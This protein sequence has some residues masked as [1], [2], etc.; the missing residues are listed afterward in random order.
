MPLFEAATKQSPSERALFIA[1]A[2]RKYPDLGKDL[3]EMV[4]AHECPTAESGPAA[5]KRDGPAIGLHAGEVL[6]E[7]FQLLERIGS[8]GMGEVFEALDLELNQKV[9]LKTIR[10]DALQSASSIS[11][12]KQE[13]QLARR[14]TGPNVC[15]IY[16]FFL[17]PRS[18]GQGRSAFL[19]MELLEGTTLFQR[20]RE[21]GSLPAS[22]VRQI[23]LDLCE[24]LRTIHQVGIVH[25]DIKPRNVMLVERDGRE[26]AVLMDFGVARDRLHGDGGESALQIAGTPDYMAPE[27]FEGRAATPATDVYA[28]GLLIYEM[29]SGKR[30]FAAATPMAAAARRASHLE[31]VSLLA[32]HCPRHWNGI[33][34]RCL[35][36]DPACRYPSAEALAR[37][38]RRGVFHPAN[39][40]RSHPRALVAACVLGAAALAWGGGRLWQ[41]AHYLRPNAAAERWCS[42]GLRALREGSYLRAIRS[43]QQ[44]IRGDPK[45]PMSHV[46]M[47]EAL[48]NLDF[49]ADAQR[50]LLLAMPQERR[51]SPIDRQSLTALREAIAGDYPGS[52]ESY[53]NILRRLPPADRSGGEIELG[54][55]HERAGDIPQAMSAYETAARLDAANPGPPMH[56]AV[57][58]AR[59]RHIEQSE[60]FFR[61]ARDLFSAEVNQ[62]GL[63]ELDYQQGYTL[64]ESGRPDEAQQYLNRA[65]DEAVAIDSVQLRIRALMQ[66]SSAANLSGKAA[67]SE[68]YAQQGLALA[69]DYRLEVWAAD[70]IAHAASAQLSQGK[71]QEAERNAR[72]ALLLATQSG[73]LRVQAMGNLIL[74]SVMDQEHRPDQVTARAQ[75]ARDYYQTHGYVAPAISAGVLLVRAQTAVGQYGPALKAATELAGLAERAGSRTNRM[76]AEEAIGDILQDEEVYPDALTHYERALSL[77][78]GSNR[79][80]EAVNCAVALVKLGRYT[81]ADAMLKTVPEDSPAEGNIELSRV[82]L[83]MSRQQYADAARRAAG[84]LRDPDIEGYPDLDLEVKLISLVALAHSGHTRVALQSITQLSQGK[85][86]NP[87]LAAARIAFA[88]ADIA[89]AERDFP[90]ARELAAQAATYFGSQGQLDSELQA[91]SIGQRAVMSEGDAASARPYQKY[92]LDIAAH[93]QQSWGPL[94]FAVYLQRSDLRIIA[95]QIQP[96]LEK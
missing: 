36:Y 89:L 64:N 81:E 44:A 48:F 45:F 38:I 68:A 96:S 24:G 3:A 30:A 51:L 20:I 86:S 6:L 60:K 9:A 54:M 92:M 74:A 88:A 82:A 70:G 23:A 13:V 32:P 53:K 58:E 41:S 15:R 47:A 18:A 19:T 7:R 76:L 95:S 10:A 79:D 22:E 84:M 2:C 75:A 93:M 55:A 34:E 11:Q 65:L 59:Q 40:R 16:E 71:L 77:A 37:D 33:V 62:E 14:A 4:A 43:E 67:E 72:E 29:L 57:L 80:F 26:Q 91:I 66:L 50:E 73:Q 61:T 12:F 46:W 27:Q 25:R 35:E 85:Y 8:G 31:S 56:L 94:A 21:R 28:M 49:Q 63:A 5:N 17:L 1:D 83:Q 87:A 90:E 69:R 39:L 78:E 42:S 52:I